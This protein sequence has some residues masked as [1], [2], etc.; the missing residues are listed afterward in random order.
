MMPMTDMDKRQAQ[1]V[2]QS[3]R[4]RGGDAPGK[5]ASGRPATRQ[6][7]RKDN[8]WATFNSFVD[9]IGP[10]L[11]LAE[12]AV[13]FVMF[14]HARGGVCETTV[15]LVAQGATVS[16]STAEAAMSRLNR[17][18]LIWAIWKSR[19]KSTASK[20]GIHPTPADCLDR[21]L[22][23]GQPS[24]SSG[25]SAGGTVPIEAGNRPDHRDIYRK[26][27]GRRQ[28]PRPDERNEAAAGTVAAD[29]GHP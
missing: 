29:G 10:R 13:W 14:R 7:A 4:D 16:R 27:K 2:A 19:D 5:P 25:R 12:R 18:G 20:Y 21:L 6:P 1:R 3:R 23:P 15:R 28:T 9:V 26:Q 8:R 24:R 17:A 22:A 11:T